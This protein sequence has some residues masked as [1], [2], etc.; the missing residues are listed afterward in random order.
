MRLLV[1]GAGGVGTAVARTIAKWD[2]FGRVVVADYRAERAERAVSG[3]PDRFGSVRLDA[4]DETATV[5]LLVSERIDA[6]LNAVDPRFVMPIFR[7]CLE[8][9]APTSTWRCRCRTRTRRTR[10]QRPA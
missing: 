7:A 9:G 6:V 8:A 2:L 1:I 5:E 4:S 10:T 3:L